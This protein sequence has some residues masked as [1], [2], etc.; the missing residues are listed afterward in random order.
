[1]TSPPSSQPVAV[2]GVTTAQTCQVLRGR[3]R[4]LRLAG[5]RVVLISSPGPLLDATTTSEGVEAAAIPIEREIKPW[6]DLVSLA[7]IWRLLQ[8]LH[9]DLVEFSTPKAGLLGLVAAR[10]YGIQR[11]VYLLRGL[12]LETSKG[13]KRRLLIA[14]ERIA[15]RSA[16]LVIA[17]SASLRHK[18]LALGLVSPERLWLLGGGSSRG[19]DVTS[20]SP[21]QSDVRKQLGIAADTLVVGFVGRLTRDKGVPE[22][23]EAF[24]QILQQHNEAQLLLV[25]WFDAAED[26]LP[27]AL[28]RKIETH[29]QIVV[30]GM[31]DSTQAYYRAMDVMVLPTL[32]EGF[33]NAV[34][35]ASATGIPVVTTLATGARDSVV[36]EVTGLLVPQGHP[37]AIAEAVLTLLNDPARRVRMGHAARAWVLENF[38][39]VQVLALTVKLYKRLLETPPNSPFRKRAKGDKMPETLADLELEAQ[40]RRA[41]WS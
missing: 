27:A 41:G 21:G 6:A 11:R 34:L 15:C 28:R 31:V 3:L 5:F 10:L 18:A 16:H 7:R 29:P 17:N 35:E 23:L 33:P 37:E 14:A 13:L 2:V 20:Y 8:R 19:V 40:W 4:A 32:R 26:A 36:P 22:L 39:D 30:T 9:P 12:K 1:M 38:V 24:E 25:G